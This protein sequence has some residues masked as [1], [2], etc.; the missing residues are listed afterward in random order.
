MEPAKY[1]VPGELEAYLNLKHGLDAV[2]TDVHALKVHVKHL[3][4]ILA[5]WRDVRAGA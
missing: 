5:N 3:L 4:Q 1:H 2:V